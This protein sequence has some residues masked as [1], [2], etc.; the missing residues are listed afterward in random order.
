MTGTENGNKCLKRRG[1]EC[2]LIKQV[3]Y[4]RQQG[5]VVTEAQW[6]KHALSKNEQQLRH[7]QIVA[8]FPDLPIFQGKLEI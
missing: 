8:E 6:R 5:V 4:K 1:K 3:G 7:Q 2:Q